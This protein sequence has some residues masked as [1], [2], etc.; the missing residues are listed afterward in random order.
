VPPL[1]PYLLYARNPYF[2]RRIDDVG[3]HPGSLP[4]STGC[5]QGAAQP[6]GCF[7]ERLPVLNGL[8]RCRGQQTWR[9][10]GKDQ[11]ARRIREQPSFH[12]SGE[13]RS[14]YAD[15]ITDTARDVDDELFRCVQRY[16]AD[17]TIAELTMI[18][19]GRT[20]LAL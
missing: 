17:D 9:P 1:Y 13:D 16:Y 14:K 12:R 6:S 11:R 5:A 10:D 2:P 8:E 20:V 15:A 7:V 4:K 3:N 18:T 19:P